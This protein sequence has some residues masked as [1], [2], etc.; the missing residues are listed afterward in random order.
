MNRKHPGFTLVELMLAMSI[1]S[2]LLLAIAFLVIQIG[3]VYTKGMT[4]KGLNQVATTISRDVERTVAQSDASEF[5]S[6]PQLPSTNGSGRICTGAVTYAWNSALDSASR[7]ATRN[8]YIGSEAGIEIHFAR[9]DDRNGI[10]CKPVSGVY[11]SIDKNK[12]REMLPAGQYDFAMHQF[13][14]GTNPTDPSLHWIVMKIGSTNTTDVDLATQQCTLN[15]GQS[16]YCAINV[17]ESTVRSARR[18]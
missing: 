9:V 14:I 1:V 16:D 8:T 15:S 10:L 4:L 5:L 12:A 2:L 7:I 13:Y 17:F 3:H 6:V 11:P 18:T